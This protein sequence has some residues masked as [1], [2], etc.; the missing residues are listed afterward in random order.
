MEEWACRREKAIQQQVLKG[1]DM[2]GIGET[3]RNLRE[4][5]G[6]TQDSL[7]E[8]A[9]VSRAI[10]TQV[11][12][13]RREPESLEL[14]RIADFFGCTVSDLLRIEPEDLDTVGVRFRRAMDMEDSSEIDEAV[15]RSIRIAREAAN[16]REIL[17]ADA[18]DSVVPRYMLN[19]PISKG[20][21]IRQGNR[22]AVLERT[23]LG[24][25]TDR[26]ESIGEV[27]E[28]QGV[29]S[30]DLPL[31]EDVSGL[32]I[33]MG[34][35]GAVCLVNKDQPALRKRFSLAHEYGH[36]LM[37][38]HM[39]SVVSRGRQREELAE[40][41][42]NAFAAAFLMPED[43]CLEMVRKIGKGAP[44]RERT[45][46]YDEEEVTRVEERSI[47]GEQELHLIDV[48]RLAFYFGVSM[49]AMLYRLRNIGLINQARLN[50]LR[51]QEDGEAGARL[52]LLMQ[53][54]GSK[55]CSE[56]PDLFRNTLINMALEALRR[57]R[58]GRGKCLQIGRLICSG[59]QL[60]IFEDL[61]CETSPEP[62]PVLVPGEDQPQDS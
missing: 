6:A 27:V 56:E 32:T 40:V 8:W 5:M 44:S 2:S 45:E 49:Q 31:P 17:G 9:G 3:I 35:L 23:R 39:P 50:E 12:A 52:R 28:A 51:Q 47:A 58:I 10:I 7:A 34:S 55:V 57:D 24:L 37:D 13:G 60:E 15:S 25:G 53:H 59:E 41:R 11:E 30:G 54:N 19:G 20:E 26:I 14:F 38:S 46:L 48:A 16:L 36:V 29:Y 42:A 1:G 61:V 22:T 62:V 4:R 43:G 18:S 21:A 33:N